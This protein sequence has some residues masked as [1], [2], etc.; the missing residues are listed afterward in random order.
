[1]DAADAELRGLLDLVVPRLDEEPCDWADVL[2]RV[3]GQR[4]RRTGRPRRAVVALAGAA[5]VAGAAA[6][7]S[8]AIGQAVRDLAGTVSSWVLGAPGDPAPSPAREEFAAANEA[9]LLAFPTGTDLR[10]LARSSAAGVEVSL[11]G[12]RVGDELCL[13][14]VGTGVEAPR[15]TGC[16]PAADVSA[17]DGALVVGSDLVLGG[18]AVTYGFALDGV[19]RVDVVG[20]ATTPAV[21][22]ANAFLAAAPVGDPV[23]EVV[24]YGGAGA[25]HVPVVPAPSGEGPGGTAPAAEQP[26][27]ASA[28]RTLA[29]SG[30]GWLDRREPRGGPLPAG[31]RVSNRLDGWG[32]IAFGRAI[33]LPGGAAIYVALADDDA[34]ARQACFGVALPLSVLGAACGGADGLFAHGPVSALVVQAQGSD[35]RQTIGGVASDA[36][37][38]LTAFPASGRPLTVPLVD[39]AFALTLP[40]TAFPVRLVALDEGGDVIGTT[41]HRDVAADPGEAPLAG[42]M[43]LA[44]TATGRN[45][46]VARLWTSSSVAGGRCLRLVVDG[47]RRHSQCLPPGAGGFYALAAGHGRA[48]DRFVF[49]AAPASAVSVRVRVAGRA[50]T[51]RVRAGVALVA[52]P[53]AGRAVVSALDARGRTVRSHGIQVPPG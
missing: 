11:Y 34:G 19:D 28:A 31:P 36:V 22:A 45:G 21:V 18:A 14:V 48:V 32:T 35:Q 3:P 41:Q 15:P 6:P 51:A 30:I 25:S 16:V 4:P 49:G 52:A 2:R 23:R 43:T 40:R 44:A 7:F 42:A 12:F 53:G 46:H 9:A 29:G 20:G 24:A 50:S 13:R 5:L 17:A 47:E 27:A 8:G 33:S 1:M 38:L 39:N 26:A 10:L 37:A